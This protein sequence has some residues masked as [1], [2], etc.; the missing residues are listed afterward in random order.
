MHIKHCLYP[1]VEATMYYIIIGGFLLW[2][3]LLSPVISPSK[4]PSRFLKCSIQEFGPFG[5]L[6]LMEEHWL[7]MSNPRI[8][9]TR[10]AGI[11]PKVTLGTS[12]RVLPACTTRFP[13]RKAMEPTGKKSQ[14]IVLWNNPYNSRCATQCVAQF[15]YV[16]LE[17]LR[18]CYII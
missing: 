4:W 11:T 18:K 16:F 5:R 9:P 1:L 10:R 8:W 17:F 3:R 14:I 12:T 13:W 6:A 15:Y 2:Q 7:L